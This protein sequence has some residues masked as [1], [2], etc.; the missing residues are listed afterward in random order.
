MKSTLTA[1]LF[2]SC[3]ISYAQDQDY[4]KVI[5]QE[6]PDFY[7]AFSSGI[8]N[9]TGLF[10]I[11]GM[12]TLSDKFLVRGGAGFGSWGGKLSLGFKYQDLMESGIGV[13]L[14]YSYVTGLEELD[15]VLP[16]QNGDETTVNMDLNR[17]GSVNLT[18]NKNWLFKRGNVFYLETGY[19]IGVGKNPYYEINDG[20][21]LSNDAEL[22][23]EILRPGGLIL[24]GGFL[25]AF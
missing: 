15:L 23:M 14:G 22:I 8:D 10:G 21:T 16:D 7:L 6:R 1:F 17:A 9:Y 24:A 20:S 4:I 2:L 18:L 13:G 3:V 25:L 19:A 11:G 12:V 5:K